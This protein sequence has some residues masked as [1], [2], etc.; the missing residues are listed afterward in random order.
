MFFLQDSW[1]FHVL[2]PAPLFEFFLDGWKSPMF[3]G[4]YGTLCMLYDAIKLLDVSIVT[5]MNLRT[6]FKFA[7][8][9]Q[10]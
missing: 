6:Q 9:L 7:V 2:S 1:K 8:M 4:I 5:Y 3:D 10:F